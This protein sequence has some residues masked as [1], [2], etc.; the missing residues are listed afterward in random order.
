[1]L[2]IHT[3][4]RW[5][6]FYRDL[7]AYKFRRTKMFF[8]RL[9]QV[10]CSRCGC[11]HTVIGTSYYDERSMVEYEELC[12]NCGTFVNRWAYGHYEFPETYTKKLR[13]WMY[14]HSPIGGYL[15]KRRT[16]RLAKKYH[17]RRMKNGNV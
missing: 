14:V 4:T 16:K 9:N 3:L 5:Y 1:M 15:F 7:I 10:G 8:R 11:K 2:L 13:F 6:M 17:K 12:K